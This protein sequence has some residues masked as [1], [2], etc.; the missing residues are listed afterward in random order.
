MSSK[1]KKS[2]FPDWHDWA[3]GNTVRYLGSGQG[4]EDCYC[5]MTVGTDYLIQEAPD[6]MESMLVLDDDGDEISVLVGEFK[7][8]KP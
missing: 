6:D 5:H 1:N 2:S 3:V 4:G 7:W 8:V